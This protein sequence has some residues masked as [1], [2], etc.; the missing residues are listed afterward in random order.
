MAR[1]EKKIL[2]GSLRVE[3]VE[4]HD[5]GLGLNDLEEG[6]HVEDENQGCELIIHEE[7]FRDTYFDHRI[8][9]ALWNQHQ[10]PEELYAVEDCELSHVGASVVQSFTDGTV[11]QIGQNFGSKDELKTSYKK[12]Q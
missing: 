4:K 1:D 8:K 10:F 2:R 3:F 7:R 5:S 12:L 6:L 9:Q 11:L